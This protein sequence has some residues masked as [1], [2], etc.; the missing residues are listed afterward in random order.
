[1]QKRIVGA[2]GVVVLAWASWWGWM[3]WDTEYQ[4]DPA[5]GNESGP[6]ETWQ[7]VGSALCVVLLVAVAT[8]VRGRRT[9]IVATTLGYTLGWCVTSL[10]E[11]ESGLA[12]VGAFMV[13]V[14]VGAGSAVVAWLA[15][16]LLH[17]R[18]ARA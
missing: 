7:V 13:L 14:G 4:L 12:L 6:Y 11:D 17:R 10:P 5:T 18:P 1:M 15:D 8:L 3:G 9:A 2:L 16:R